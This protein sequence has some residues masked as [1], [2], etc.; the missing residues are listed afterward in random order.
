MKEE[1]PPNCLAPVC[2]FSSSSFQVIFQDFFSSICAV[3]KRR[4][5][6]EVGGGKNNSY[7]PCGTVELN[8]I[9]PLEKKEF[10]D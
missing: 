3:K 4:E 5:E 8:F 2:S 6:E 1:V 9:V 7:T 10:H